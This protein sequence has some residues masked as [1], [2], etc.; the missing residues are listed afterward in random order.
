MVLTKLLYFG[1]Q[2]THLALREIS[3]RKRLEL[4]MQS[5][6]EEAVN[7]NKVKSEFLAKMSHEIR[8][9]L[10][11]I[12][13]YAQMGESK[14]E[15]LSKEKIERYFSN[16]HKS[17]ERLMALLD[18]LRDLSKVES[19]MLSYDFKYQNINTTIQNCIEQQRPLLT[20]KQ[21][22]LDCEG[23]DLMAYFDKARITQVVSNLLVNAI[24]HTPY[25][26]KIQIKAKQLEKGV[27]QCCIHDNG[28]G[29]DKDEL[30]L[31]FETYKQGKKHT[32]NNEGSGLGLAISREI[33]EAHQGSIWAG[34]R[35]SEHETS[36]SGAM[37]CFTLP[38]QKPVDGKI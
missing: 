13:S 28:I 32:G 6:R 10:H 35:V 36:L 22:E 5:A 16:I 21:I 14:L 25:N 1:R 9:P 30:E 38:S 24:K 15:Q 2:V 23:H 17:G 19:G 18:D 3:E 8:T 31:I 27:I 4:E 37:F 20:E 33:I 29:I 26:G 12:L 34:S 7:A 11:G